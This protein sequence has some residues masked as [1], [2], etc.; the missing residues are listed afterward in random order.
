MQDELQEPIT[1][2]IGNLCDGKIIDAFE[3][4]L[5]KCIN[6]IFDLGVPASANRTIVLR[7]KLKPDDARVKIAA[8]FTCESSLAQPHPVT[9]VFFV[10]KDR[11]TGMVYGLTSDPRQRSIVFDAPKPKEPPKPLEFVAAGK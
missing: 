2:N 7:V 8:E 6:N 10:G 3:Q 9:D 4:E 11:E 1:I 5:Q